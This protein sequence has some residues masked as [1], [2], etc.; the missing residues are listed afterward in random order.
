MVVAQMPRENILSRA[1][2][3]CGETEQP[4]LN[5]LQSAPTLTMVAGWTSRH[6]IIPDMLASHMARDNVINGH[7]RG[8]LPTI[9]AGVIIPAQDLALG[10]LDARSWAPDHL[11]QTN[12]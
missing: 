3:F 8:M 11:F 9:L 5:L 12:D 1:G 10:Q 6:Y 7:K 4:H 2:G